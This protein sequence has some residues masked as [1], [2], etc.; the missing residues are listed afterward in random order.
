M[1]SLFLI[2]PTRAESDLEMLPKGLELLK[3]GSDLLDSKDKSTNMEHT[4]IMNSRF[5]PSSQ[6]A[7]GRLR[8]RNFSD[9]ELEPSFG[10]SP[11]TTSRLMNRLSKNIDSYME[12]RVIEDYEE[13]LPSDRY[14]DNQPEQ[15]TSQEFEPS[16]RDRYRASKSRVLDLPVSESKQD[17][18]FGRVPSLKGVTGNSRVLSLNKIEATPKSLFGRKEVPKNVES[19]AESRILEDIEEILPTDNFKDNQKDQVSV[20]DFEH[21]VRD[22]YRSTKSKLWLEVPGSNKDL[23]SRIQSLRNITGNPR[24]FSMNRFDVTPKSPLG[25][26]SRNEKEECIDEKSLEISD[27]GESPQKVGDKKRMRKLLV[28]NSQ[29]SISRL[30]DMESSRVFE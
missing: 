23:D 25:S 27:G 26:V 5:T 15:V 4:E 12:S 11:K 29:M 9:S 17:M 16:V 30:G 6:R 18:D 13:V 8:L 1:K 20:Q 19:Y 24:V 21:S 22:R 10:P 2:K 14:K 28:G 7:S 3:M